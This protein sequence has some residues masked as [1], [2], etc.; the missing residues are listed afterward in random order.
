MSKEKIKEELERLYFEADEAR[1][2]EV[3]EAEYNLHAGKSEA[4]AK[5]LELLDSL[6]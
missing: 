5:A 3:D 2:K 1:E 6:I 4:Y